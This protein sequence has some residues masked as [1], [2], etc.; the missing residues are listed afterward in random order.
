M[1][2]WLIILFGA[3]ALAPP[4]F[5]RMGGS[6][7]AALALVPASAFVYFLMQMPAIRRGVVAVESL[8]WIPA[9]DIEFALQLDGLAALFALLIT[10]I[11]A[12]VVWYAGAYLHTDPER[13]RFIAVLMLFMASML[14]VVLANNVI[15]LFLFWE[16][17]SF[18]SYLL[19]GHNHDEEKARKAALQALLVTGLGGLFLL[20]GLLLLARAAGTYNLSELLAAPGLVEHALFGPAL[21]LILVG[22]FTKSAQ[23]PFHFWLPN[24]MAAPTPASAYLHS[25]TMVKAGVYLLAR[26]HPTCAEAELWMPLVTGAGAA[27]LLIGATMAY[28]QT[29][30]KRLLAYTT[31]GAL[32]AMTMLLGLGTPHAAKAVVTFLLAHALYKATLFLVAGIIDHETGEKDVKKLGGLRRAMPFTSAAGG[33]AALSMMGLPP[34]FGFLGKELLYGA[35]TLHGILAVSIIASAFF[36]VVAFL[37]GF[38]PFVGA[39]RETPRAPHEAPAAMWSGPLTLGALGLLFGLAAPWIGD[40]L[41]APAAGAIS[42]SPVH[43]KLALWHGFTQELMLS[44]LTV[45]LGLVAI[46][47]WPAIRARAAAFAVLARLGPDRGY[48]AALRLLTG[49]AAVQTRLLQS[50]SLRSYLLTIMV[51]LLATSGWY[52]FRANIHPEIGALTPID[53]NDVVVV[54]L[55]LISTFGALFSRSRMA[56]IASLGVVGYAVAIFFVFYGAPDLAMTQFVIETLT[57]ILFV[58]SFYHLPPFTGRSS[59]GARA[60]DFGV[61]ALVGLFMAALAFAANRTELAPSIARYFSEHSWT[62]AYGRNIVN[63]I[64]VDFRAID[65]L[66]EITVLVVAGLGVVSLLKLRLRGKD[67]A[68]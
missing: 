24:A 19:I 30:L 47:A 65:T 20:A 50:G 66:G 23:F 12:F 58:L 61:A 34:F 28:G 52:Y 48:D 33:L 62:S 63:V 7:A 29:I 3:G 54:A 64:L 14:G 35:G 45:V 40:A 25:S 42:G 8:P 16:L 11:G 9:L 38:R 57:V 39:Q 13:P 32:G 51:F 1:L 68:S 37:T 10:G 2:I 22:A 59:R 5:R 60:L 4:L 67:G 15:A 36:F 31:V 55:I 49:T 56:A 27:T 6:A 44:G 46:A 53:R 26:L 43:A 41:L 17:T 18:T 21:L